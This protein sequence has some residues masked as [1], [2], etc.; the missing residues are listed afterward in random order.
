MNSKFQVHGL[1][2]HFGYV[3]SQMA[4]TLMVWHYDGFKTKEEALTDFAHF[5]FEDYVESVERTNRYIERQQPVTRPSMELDVYDFIDFLRQSL[6]FVASAGP[7]E[8]TFGQP[9]SDHETWNGF[10]SFS[11][12]VEHVRYVAVIEERA[13]EVLAYYLDARKIKDAWFKASLKEWRKDYRGM[14]F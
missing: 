5:M 11:F 14:G 12:F 7:N 6:R 8:H 3:E 4:G 13:E 1:V 9:G 10:E 2:L